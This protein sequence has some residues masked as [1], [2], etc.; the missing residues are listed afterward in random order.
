MF[1]N[2]IYN[3]TN[4]NSNAALITVYLGHITFFYP[5]QISRLAFV[6]HVTVNDAVHCHYVEPDSL[7]LHDCAL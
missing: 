4:R 2:T 6:D 3:G 5:R 1:G 7:V